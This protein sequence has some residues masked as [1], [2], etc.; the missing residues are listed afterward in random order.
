L[1]VSP[2]QERLNL[3]F[4]TEGK[5]TAI[6]II[7]SSWGSQRAGHSPRIKLIF[8]RR[9]RGE[10]WKTSARGVFHTHILYFVIVLLYLIYFYLHRFI[11]KTQKTLE[12]LV[13]V[14]TY[15]LLV[16]LKWLILKTPSCVT[17]LA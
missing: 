7:P 13:V 4:L 15:L 12:S 1:F 9:C 17:L 2:P 16:L 10:E 11:S 14:F 6:L 8:W 3:G 5:L